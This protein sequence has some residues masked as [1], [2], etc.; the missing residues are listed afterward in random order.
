M[1]AHTSASVLTVY[2][3]LVK[4]QGAS[5]TARA[6]T[7]ECAGGDGSENVSVVKSELMEGF[8]LKGTMGA[9]KEAAQKLLSTVIAP[10]NSG[11]LFL[12]FSFFE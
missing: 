6:S 4:L 9:P 7:V 10:E 8:S 12:W 5:E 11:A 3:V 1:G 2:D